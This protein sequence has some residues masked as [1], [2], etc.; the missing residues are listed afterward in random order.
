[1]NAIRCAAILA[2]TLIGVVSCSTSSGDRDID[3]ERGI[4]QECAFGSGAKPAH[5]C[6]GYIVSK[7]G[8]WRAPMAREEFC[9]SLTAGRGAYSDGYCSL[10]CRGQNE[11]IVE[12]QPRSPDRLIGCAVCARP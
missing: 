5:D 2:L 11:I 1:M 3:R 9:T 6:C 8:R 4:S 7:T 10:D 12:L